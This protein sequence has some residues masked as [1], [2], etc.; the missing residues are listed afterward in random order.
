MQAVVFTLGCKVN[1]YES[2]VLAQQLRELGYEV[3][4]DLI[5]A[6]VY[7][8]NTCAV[9]AEAERKSRQAVARCRALNNNAKIF[10]CGCASE[11]KFSVFEKDNVVFIGGTA[12]KDKIIERLEDENFSY[13]IEKTPLIYENATLKT[14]DRTRAYVKIQDGCNSFCSY[15]IIPYLRGRSRSRALDEVL[16]EIDILKDKTAEIVL[17]GINVMSYGIDIGTNLTEL[18]KRLKGYEGRLRLSS[19][20]AEGITEELLDALFSIKNFCPHFHL[21]LQSGDDKVLKDMNRRYTTAVYADKIDLIR[22]YDDNAYVATDIICGYPTEDE[23]NFCNTVRFINDVK[24]ADLHV[25]P[26][27]PRE[28]TRAFKLSKLPTDTVKARRDELLNL[29]RELHLEYLKRNI[30]KKQDVLLE[31]RDGDYNSGYS[32]YYIKIYTPNG[33]ISDN[34]NKSGVVSCT[35]KSIYKEGLKED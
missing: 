20:Y 22:R 2:D 31:E 11:R 33:T 8:L 21:S 6:D 16:K 15:C 17:T 34:G 29:K 23:D 3:S 12:Y 14:S 7:I 28:G 5:Y 27:S 32:Q 4:E 35:P 26:Y 13:A 25:F 24:F 1:Q 10:V 30:G 18:I 19:F 9:T